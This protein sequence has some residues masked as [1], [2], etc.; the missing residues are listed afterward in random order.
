[1]LD[2]KRDVEALFRIDRWRPESTF[3][4]RV[5]DAAAEALAEH[6]PEL[7]FSLEGMKADLDKQIADIKLKLNRKK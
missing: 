4:G 2:D 6:H 5:C 1:M 3:P 7:K